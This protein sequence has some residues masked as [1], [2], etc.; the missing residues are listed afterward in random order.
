MKMF[1]FEENKRWWQHLW[2]IPMQLIVAVLAYI[3]ASLRD[4]ARLA[5]GKGHLYTVLCIVICGLIT[6]A[7]TVR[8]V[9]LAV[10]T[11]KNEKEGGRTGTGSDEAKKPRKMPN[12]IPLQIALDIVVLGLSFYIELTNFEATEEL[13]FHLPVVSLILTFIMLVIT[14]I[15]IALSSA[16][17]GKKSGSGSSENENSGARKRKARKK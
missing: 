10:Q 15:V 1:K 8:A 5:A 4:A 17:R 11:L 16:S 14:G 6:A 12:L 7:V 13:G 9:M 2:P 3:V